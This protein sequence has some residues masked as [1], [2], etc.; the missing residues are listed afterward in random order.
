MSTKKKLAIIH[1]LSKGGS[2]RVLEEQ[3]KLLSKKYNLQIFSPQKYKASN[4]NSVA[5]ILTYLKYLY[6]TLPKE[7]LKISKIVNSDSF[8]AAIIHHDSYVKTPL[9]LQWINIKTIYILHEPPREFYEPIDYHAPL[10]KDKIIFYFR[11]P[12]YIIDKILTKKA[13]YVIVNSKFSKK[14]V[15]KIYKIKSKIIYCGSSKKFQHTNSIRSFQCLS[16]GS[17]L[18]Y[19]GHKLTISALSKLKEKPR[20]IIV[21]SGRKKEIGN[22]EQFAKKKNVDVEIIN[23]LSDKKMNKLYNRVKLFINSAYKEPF[24]LSALEALSVGTS[25]VSVNDCGTIELKK[26]FP[27]QFMVV[28]RNPKSI[29]NGIR[30]ALNVSVSTR[31]AV[32]RIFRWSNNVKKLEEVI[33]ND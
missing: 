8:S 10:I 7:Y 4:G 32:P 17:L 15:D 31:A 22:L 30:K 29:A 16:V 24:G 18:P 23:S 11:L 9:A 6:W 5:K 13:D 27:K 33:N 14:R 3:N 28:D 25:V 19:K 26:Y 20:L 1:N 21:G 12:I 2:V